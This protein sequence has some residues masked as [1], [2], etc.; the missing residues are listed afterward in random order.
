M[1][2]QKGFAHTALL[3]VVFVIAFVSAVGFYV[4]K[5]KSDKPS[6][7]TTDSSSAE[8]IEQSEEKSG[9]PQDKDALEKEDESDKADD[10]KNDEKPTKSP[11][12]SVS[13]KPV[14]NTKNC[15]P[16]DADKYQKTYSG[17]SNSG[18]LKSN[19][20]SDAKKFYDALKFAGL[21]SKIDSS[22]VV[23][24]APNDYVYENK[25]TDE[26]L[27]FMNA[28]PAN[29][30][31]VLGWHI[32]TS[33]VVWDSN[34]ENV[35]GSVTLT[36]L[37]GKVTYTQGSPGKINDARLAIWDWYTSNGAVHFIGDFIKPPKL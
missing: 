22:K 19:G 28:S 5:S 29:M 18:F 10:S 33:C 15:L 8:M 27:A 9:I 14:A 2:D 4:M 25:L 17:I 3:I 24:F 21:I 30:K 16:P 7:N 31:S 35:K 12:S 11:S 26:Q 23:V 13:S 37:N 36:T 34:M 6:L 20:Y 1:K 32:V